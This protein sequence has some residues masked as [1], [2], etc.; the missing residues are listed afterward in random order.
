MNIEF[1]CCCLSIAPELYLQLNKAIKNK[2]VDVDAN[3]ITVNF[4]DSSYSASAG[5]YHPV[6][7][8]F[9]KDESNG[10]WSLQ[11]ITDFCY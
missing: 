10:K 4:R 3:Q 11:Y 2:K 5:G 9:R 1:D 7:I 8:S 6:E